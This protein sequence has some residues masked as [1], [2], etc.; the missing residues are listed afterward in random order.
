M[1]D[2]YSAALSNGNSSIVTNM[3]NHIHER[4]MQQGFGTAASKGCRSDGRSL[5]AVR[6]ISATAPIFP[7]CV[8]GSAIFSRGETQVLCTAT[9]TYKCNRHQK[10]MSVH[11]P[12]YVRLH[13]QRGGVN[14]LMSSFF[15]SSSKYLLPK[16]VCLW[17]ILYQ[18]LCGVR[19]T[20][21]KQQMTTRCR[22]VV[23]DSCALRLNWNVSKDG[24]TIQALSLHLELIDADL[25]SRH[26][27][28]KSKSWAGT[29]W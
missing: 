4:I 22:L 3:R 23:F 15:Y 11:V 16:M 19:S 5:I 9:G 2:E 10:A 13:F 26:E 17:Q 27:L 6:P 21:T 8:H 24:P 12:T 1:G 25:N 20:L 29:Y 7:D 28:T 18:S 14:T